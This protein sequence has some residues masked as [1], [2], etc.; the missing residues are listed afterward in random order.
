MVTSIE[1]FTNAGPDIKAHVTGVSGKLILTC[2]MTAPY[3]AIEGHEWMHGDKILQTDTES[4][5]FT[6]YT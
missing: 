6:S 2:N 3:P 5:S 1:L 4:S